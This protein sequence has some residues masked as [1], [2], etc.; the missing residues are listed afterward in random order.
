MCPISRL[1]SPG[2]S[3]QKMYGEL[4]VGPVYGCGGNSG[5]GR[6]QSFT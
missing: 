5:R 1:G 2:E 6:C 3:V 4:T